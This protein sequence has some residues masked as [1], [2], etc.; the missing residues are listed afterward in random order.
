MKPYTVLNNK[1][2]MIMNRLR[3]SVAAIALFAA[4]TT[5]AQVLT[6]GEAVPQGAIIYSLPSTTISLKATAEREAFIAGPYAAYANKYLGVDAKKANTNT[7]K[8]SEIEMIPL[9]EADP[10]MSAAVNLGSSKAASAN[11]LNFC[12]QGLIVASD[13]YTG[14]NVPWRFPSAVNNSDFNTVTNVPNLSNRSTVLYK[15]VET[16]DGIEK[17]PVQQSQIVE[18]S[19]EKKA[20]EVANLIFTLR[21]KRIDILT[22]DTDVTY[23]G[24]AM[25]AVLSEITRLE[26]EFLSLFLGKSTKE[27]QTIIFDVIPAASNNKQM[28]IAFRVSDTQG[29]LPSN[30]VGGRPIVLELVADGEQIQNVSAAE[31]ASATKGRVAYRKPVT[32]TARVLDG[33][34]VLLQG[35]VPV[36][37]FGK[38]LS[39]PIDIAAK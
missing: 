19:P 10:N 37:Q 27:T 18:K 9:V 17:V 16:P 29:L 3:I 25:N 26:Q 20:E 12:S 30:N 23:S 1:L 31:A 2:N 5:N 32:V 35:R 21:Q 28:Y 14:Q 11:F 13:G 6:P 15:T 22:G 33:Q 36:Y 24:E 34:N 8:I 38:V 4:L 39:F 7:Y